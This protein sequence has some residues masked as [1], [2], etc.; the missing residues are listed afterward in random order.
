M[1]RSIDH[2]S[3]RQAKQIMRRNRILLHERH[4]NVSSWAN[5]LKIK[6]HG[7]EG[8]RRKTPQGGRKFAHKHWEN[9][10][11]LRM[12]YM[13]GEEIAE[14][15]AFDEGERERKR[16]VEERKRETGKRQWN[17]DR[18]WEV[19]PSILWSIESTICRPLILLC[20]FFSV[21]FR[22]EIDPFK[23]EI[24]II[25]VFIYRY[26]ILTSNHF[27]IF[28]VVVMLPIAVHYAETKSAIFQLTIQMFWGPCD[29]LCN[30]I[31][32]MEL[33]ICVLHILLSGNRIIF[34]GMLETFHFNCI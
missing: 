27:H 13:K 6:W 30:A 3:K 25:W 11:M 17:R 31:M 23:M 7:I 12:Y 18:N 8:G 26:S 28:F 19:K 10:R 14:D 4:K 16:H 15:D 9:R 22:Y 24:D 5:S 33:F 29:C 2:F 20:S 1:L 21:L 32:W 34:H